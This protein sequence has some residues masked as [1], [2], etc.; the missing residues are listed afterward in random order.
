M[1]FDYYVFGLFFVGGISFYVRI[2]KKFCRKV[3]WVRNGG[4]LLMI[5]I[6]LLVIEVGYFG[7]NFLVLVRF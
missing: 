6:N 5:R 2:F 4:F 1:V 3:Y 7:S